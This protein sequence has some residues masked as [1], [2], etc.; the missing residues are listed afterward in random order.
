MKILIFLVSFSLINAQIGDLIWEENFN[1][2]DNWIKVTGNGVWGWGNGE[3]QYYIEDNIEISS[4]PNESNNNALKIIAKN[5]SGSNFSDQWGNPLYYTSGKV[6][7]QSKVSIKYGMIE[8]RVR[9]PDIN[10]GG[11]PAVWLLGSANYEWPRN[12][13]MDM[14][15]MGSR[16]SFRDLHDQHNGGDG[17]NNSNVNQVVGANAIFYSDDALTPNNPTGA[18]SISWDPDDDYCRP[19]Y[20]YSN[21]LNGRFLIY[22]KYWDEDSIR[23]TVTDNDIEYDLYTEPFMIDEESDEFKNPFYLI[24][25]LAIGGLFT[26]SQYLGGDGLPISMP[27]PS[28]MYVDY[29]KVY[30]W[31][32][33][34]E[35]NLGPPSSQSGVF[36]IFTDNTATS[37]SLEAGVNSEIYVWE[38]TLTDG[39]IAPYEGS[40]GI[41]W[42]STGLGWF[43][44]GIMS[45]QPVNLSNFGDGFL[46]FMIKIPSN[47]SFQIGIID[48][49]GN[50]SY[51][52]FPANQTTYGL[53]RDGN[54]G[55]ASIPV[56]EIRGEF[57]D[58]R[59]L[60]YEF[61][62]LEVNGTSCEFAIDDIYWDGGYDPCEGIICEDGEIC[63]EGE[64]VLD[65]CYE[66]YCEG[67]EV[68][69]EG[70][71]I[72]IPIDPCENIICNEGQECQGGECVD[73]PSDP[74]V[75][76][77]VD[78]TNEEIDDSG[79]YVSGSDLQLAGPSGLLMT[80]QSD[81]I[82]SLTISPTPGT[83]T[84]K[85][86]N[87]FYDYWD[88]P[89]W[90]PDLPDECGFGQW[91]DRQFIFENSDLV[92]GP[93]YFGSCEISEQQLIEGDIN[94]DGEVNIIDIIYVVNIILGDSIS[95]ESADFNQDGLINIFDILQLVN[96]IIIE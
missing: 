37:N 53:V 14:M 92:L 63:E 84:Y 30:E 93:Y 54:W 83:Y 51:V 13:E 52:E 16:Q 49:W 77:L 64:C 8:A 28:E 87:G 68:C 55:Q 62:I 20:N 48:V 72:D 85:F 17:A 19:Y 86:R 10:L 78:M 81:N 74:I 95:S 11:W 44:A 66:I 50:Q 70:E 26:D 94:N 40:N 73:L 96:I 79:V 76:F 57:I 67:G 3:L 80:E 5:E 1:N 43:G 25:N 31:N 23:F 82:W 24:V 32:Q 47:I 45:V 42:A 59:M 12:G 38:G 9:I 60:S 89:G 69:I 2:L 46:K 61:V 36:G 27:F 39:T 29:I 22:R 71:C 18:A 90:E 33:Q 6:T 35:V 56:S 88:G 75:T 4:I 91:N 21:P 41:T 58:L 15:E 7:T 34:G 65:P